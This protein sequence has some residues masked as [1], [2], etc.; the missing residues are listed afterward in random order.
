MGQG[1]AGDVIDADI[2]QGGDIFFGHVAGTFRFSPAVD[3]AT[4]SF[5]MSW[6][7][8][9]SMMMSAPAPTASRTM[10]SVSV[11]TSILRTKGA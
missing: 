10:S 1:T 4:A 3:E 6:L 5:I 8:L 9:S 11:S 2:G 7:M